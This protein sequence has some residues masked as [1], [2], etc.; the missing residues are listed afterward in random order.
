MAHFN[1]L[2]K[3]VDNVNDIKRSET[4]SEL[5]NRLK[6]LVPSTVR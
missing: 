3:C 1:K 5:I 6:Q 2:L 4:E